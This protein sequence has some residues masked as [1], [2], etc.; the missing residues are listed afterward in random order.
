MKAGVLYA[1][2]PPLFDLVFWG[3]AWFMREEPGG[4]TPPLQAFLRSLPALALLWDW[5]REDLKN[6]YVAPFYG[7]YAGA[8][9]DEEAL[10]GA[11][12]GFLLGLLWAAFVRVPRAW[13]FW[14]AL[15]FV[16]LST[17]VFTFALV[18]LGRPTGWLVP[19]IVLFYTLLEPGNAFRRA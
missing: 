3:V 9:M 14:A 6:P 11:A 7:A 19:L 8:V 1:L 17:F 16:L 10:W 4:L 15:F 2:A 13:R 18:W 12:V 5:D